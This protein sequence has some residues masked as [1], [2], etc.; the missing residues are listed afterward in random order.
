MK[1][2]KD[3]KHTHTHTHAHTVAD[4][5]AAAGTGSVDPSCSLAGARLCCSLEDGTLFDAMCN[6]TDLKKNA[7]KFYVAQLVASGNEHYLFTRWGRV[8]EAGAVQLKGPFEREQGEKEFKKQFK[9]KTANDWANRVTFVAKAGKY[10]LV[11]LDA[12]NKGKEDGVALLDSGGGAA[13]AKAST[14]EP[15][16]QELVEWI[17]S[18]DMFKNAMEEGEAL[19]VSVSVCFVKTDNEA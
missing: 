12:T 14:L 11:I 6:Q 19:C 3:F 2:T 5:A 16:T 17:L 13:G 18:K 8:G 1:Y 10:D 4:C 15:R 9:V 7:N